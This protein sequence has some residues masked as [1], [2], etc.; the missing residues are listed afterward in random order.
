MVSRFG[1]QNR[2]L[3]FGNLNIKITTTVSWFEPQ[4]QA[5]FG[6]SVAPQNRRED[7]SL[8]DT[9]RDLV[10]CFMWKRIWLGFS[11]LASRLAEARRRVVHVAPSQSLRRS[12]VEDG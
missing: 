10:A 8:C 5:Y 3:R 12:Q 1:P 6:L 7:A 4:N 11:S 2:Q 9:R